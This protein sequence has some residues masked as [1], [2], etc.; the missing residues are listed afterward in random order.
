MIYIENTL[1]NWHSR[2]SYNEI[3]SRSNG[4]GLIFFFIRDSQLTNVK[5]KSKKINQ[6]FTTLT[7]FPVQQNKQT[8]IF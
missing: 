4:I 6:Y 3:Q 1:N 7:S 8:F 5:K 2:I